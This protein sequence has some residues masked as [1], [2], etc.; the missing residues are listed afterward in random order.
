[1]EKITLHPKLGTL[2]AREASESGILDEN[3]EMFAAKLRANLARHID[4]GAAL[5]SVRIDKIPGRAPGVVDRIVSYADTNSYHGNTAKQ[6]GYFAIEFGHY[7]RNKQGRPIK[8]YPGTMALSRVMKTKLKN[9]KR[10]R[11]RLV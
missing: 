6:D 8:W 1:M 11:A 10:M 5:A 7:K 3:A 2:I 4:T 9:A